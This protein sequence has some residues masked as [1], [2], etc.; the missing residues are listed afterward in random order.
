MTVWAPA[1]LSEARPHER[2]SAQGI[3][4]ATQRNF[5]TCLADAVGLPSSL[6]LE[7]IKMQ[8]RL[9]TVI[10][11]G[12]AADEAYDESKKSATGTTF[13][14]VKSPLIEAMRTGKWVLLDSI[15]CAPQ[16]G[17]CAADIANA[18]RSLTPCAPQDVVERLNSLFEDNPEL[19]IYE[20]DGEKFFRP[21]KD[22]AS[23]APPMSRQPTAEAG[24]VKA[25][26]PPAGDAAPKKDARAEVK[27]SLTPI[28]E[29]FRL[30][31]TAN[32]ARTQSQKLSTALV[33]RCVRLSLPPIDYGLEDALSRPNDDWLTH[34]VYHLCKHGLGGIVGGEEIAVGDAAVRTRQRRPGTSLRFLRVACAR[35]GSRPHQAHAPAQRVHRARRLRPHV[36]LPGAR[37]PR[38]PAAGLQGGPAAQPSS[39][40]GADHRLSVLRPTESFSHFGVLLGGHPHLRLP[41]VEQAGA[42]AAGA[43][44]HLAHPGLCR[45]Q[46]RL[47][48]AGGALPG[49]A[50]P[51]RFSESHISPS[52]QEGRAPPL[53]GAARDGQSA[54]SCALARSQ[55]DWAPRAADGSRLCRRAR[56]RAVRGDAHRLQRTHAQSHPCGTRASEQGAQTAGATRDDGRP[57]F[58]GEWPSSASKRTREL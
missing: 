19:V 7:A 55:D 26:A 34:E 22:G 27:T 6:R 30:F 31:C 32:T 5:D 14:F 33:N 15:N 44:P 47:C 43:A 1:T 36:P 49:G 8:G 35:P 29:N 10:A 21:R 48:P 28:H 56:H 40:V 11:A 50:R 57:R 20:A 53:A 23:T 18:V 54:R 25:S 3:A 9:A 52:G 13:T 37:H 39:R 16:V 17:A 24:E 42:R 41:V 46:G 51:S 2:L 58:G 4:E 12:R 38:H 45:L